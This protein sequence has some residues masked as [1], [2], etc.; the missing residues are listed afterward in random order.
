MIM[1]VKLPRYNSH[2][3]L[4]EAEYLH[5][6]LRVPSLIIQLNQLINLKTLLF[7]NPACSC[8]L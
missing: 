2:F 3:Y 4:V 1:I 8:T 7:I 5:N 6:Q